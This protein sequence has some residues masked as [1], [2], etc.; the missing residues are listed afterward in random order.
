[1]SGGQER[2][3]VIRAL[4]AAHDSEH[5]KGCP[6]SQ[7]NLRSAPCECHVGQ[8]RF[9]I[10]VLN[11]MGRP[12]VEELRSELGASNWVIARRTPRIISK[13]GE[14]V[15]CLSP[16]KL[17]AAERRALLCRAARMGVKV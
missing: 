8:A 16:S 10:S 3:I 11:S 5:S 1:M 15:L 12:T 2:D 17:V 7:Q 14:D 13:Y 9:A 4:E 6:F